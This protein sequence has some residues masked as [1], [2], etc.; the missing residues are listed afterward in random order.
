MVSGED[1]P[2]DAAVG[3]ASTVATGAAFDGVMATDGALA[4][5]DAAGAA[6]VVAA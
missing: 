6:A 2:F 4:G 5:V 1:E 3:V